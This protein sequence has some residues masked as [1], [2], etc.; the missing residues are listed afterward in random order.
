MPAVLHGN[1]IDYEIESFV[2]AGQE[3]IVYKARVKSTKRCV[4][5][6]FRLKDSIVK[7]RKKELPVYQSLDHL[8]IIKI[9]DY[10]E[11][12]GGLRLEGEKGGIKFVIDRTKYYCVVEDF[13]TGEILEGNKSSSL[14]NY[15]KQRAPKKDASYEEVIRFQ[16]EFIF[17]WIFEFCDIMLHMTHERRILHL[18]IKPENIMVTRTGSI[19]LIDMGLS[20]FLE[21]LSAGLNLQYDFDHINI[22]CANV[23]RRYVPSDGEDVLAFA[24]GTPGFASPECY[25]KDG[26]NCEL[27]LNLKNPFY[28]GRVTDK[29]GIVDVRSDIFSFGCTLWDVINLG[30]YGTDEKHKDYISINKNETKEGYFNRDLHYASPYYLQELEDIILKC[31]E[32]NPDK[33]FQDYSELKEAAVRAKKTL[34]KS[35][36]N[37]NRVKILRRFAVIIGVLTAILFL[38]YQRGLDLGYDIAIEDF[39]TV[40][41]KYSENTNPIDFRDISLSLLSEA[42]KANANPDVIYKDIISAVNNNDKITSTEFS[43]ILYKCLGNKGVNDSITLTYINTAMKNPGEGNDITTVSK[44][45]E[46]NYKGANC[47]GYFIAAAIA[48]CKRDALGSLA[49]LEKYQDLLEYKAT[50]NYLARSLLNEEAVSNDYDDR[51]KVA[52]IREKTER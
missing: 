28:S 40:A 13:V 46:S 51:I 39:R 47:E 16:E 29:D 24:Y 12:L 34:P 27:D 15:C 42:K 37:K 31:T 22:D 7:F 41:N 4:A 30:G 14:Y 5:L 35:E 19:V 8:N 32:E 48:N 49:I 45:I 2:D 33:R 3:S 9:F 50:L 38:I 36:E 6:K 10:I 11:D 1:A 20:G 21:E 43:E 26:E 17:K 18:D 44:F 23:E 25:Y 52:A